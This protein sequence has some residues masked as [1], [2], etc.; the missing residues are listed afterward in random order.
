MK[1]VSYSNLGADAKIYQAYSV[2]SFPEEIERENKEDFFRKSLKHVRIAMLLAIGF[3]CRHVDYCDDPYRNR[4]QRRSHVQ[5]SAIVHL[6]RINF[7]TK[8]K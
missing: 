5:H 8:L 2:Q 3:A 7:P 6:L 1:T 4:I